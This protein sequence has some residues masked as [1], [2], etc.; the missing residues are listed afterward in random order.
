LPNSADPSSRT[1]GVLAAQPGLDGDRAGPAGCG[2]NQRTGGPQIMT[3]QA[4][5]PPYEPRWPVALALLAVLVVLALLPP[6]LTLLPDWSVYVAAFAMTVPVVG[7]GLTHASARWLRIE[8][9]TMLGFFGLA[10]LATLAGLAHLISV[11]VRRSSSLSGVTLLASSIGL[12]LI[13]VVTYSLIYWQLDGGGPEARL[14]RAGRRPDWLFPQHGAPDDVA[15]LG[16]RPTFV[17]YLYLAYST[18]TAFS[19]TEV[20]PLTSRAKLLMMLESGISLIVIVVVGARA[21][22]ILGGA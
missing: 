2:G 4:Q 17:D 22:N 8:H 20:I 3:R 18:A 6:R 12:W 5:S 7:V 16:W 1:D 19:T 14:N 9:A 15:P 11:M 13:N 10:T 21:I